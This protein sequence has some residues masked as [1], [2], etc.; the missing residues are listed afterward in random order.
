[1]TSVSLHWGATGV[2]KSDCAVVVDVLSFS[3]T[4]TVATDQGIEVLPYR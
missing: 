3:T 4:L 2:P 1:M